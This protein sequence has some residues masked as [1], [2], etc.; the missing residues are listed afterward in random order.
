MSDLK[1]NA[2][3]ITID[4]DS[5]K[6]LLDQAVENN[7][8]STVEQMG[9]D[10][11]WLA[12]IER[13]IN[14]AVVQRTI[15]E[16]G[17]IDIASI[18][19][20][21]VDEQMQIFKQEM[22]TKFSSTG[23]DDQ[24]TELQLT[25][26][27]DNVVIEHRLT[28]ADVDVVG[29]VITKDL[30]VKGTINTD[31]HS[32]DALAN[33]VT[34][35]TLLKL[36]DQ[37]RELLIQQVK[38]NINQDGIS[39][40]AVKIGE[41]PLVAGNRLSGSITES[42]LQKLGQVHDLTTHGSTSLSETLNVI[43]KR[44]GI[45]TDMPDHVLTLWDEEIKLSIGKYKNQEA[46]IGTGK[47]QTLNLTVNN[48]PLVTLNADGITSIK[49]LRVAQ[50]RIGHS[51]EVPNWSGTRG[52]VMFNSAP[53]VDNPAFAWVCLGAYKWKVIKSVE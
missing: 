35:K 27:D 3:A 51:P 9:Q 48:D 29:A 24:A 20:Q 28:A 42:N 39:F 25:V 22:L 17:S 6:H 4:P 37:W 26:M 45:N 49:K 16:I 15:A 52:D 43:K 10:E 18:I 23:I 44:V 31:N 50:H 13:M 40:D 38:Q 53:T 41:Q 8:L 5:I 36:N 34:E 14:Q 33:A 47:P 19:K 11:V 2:T 7:I 46:F 30:V 21:R 12:K 32:W 1:I